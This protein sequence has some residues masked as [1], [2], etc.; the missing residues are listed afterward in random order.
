MMGSSRRVDAAEA[1]ALVRDNRVSVLDVRTPEEYSSLGHIPGAI[2]LPVDLIASAPATLP[3]SGKPL[4]VCCEHGVRSAFA[5]GF[6]ARAG[7]EGVLDLAGGMAGWRGPR[8]HAP[9]GGGE[10]IG[11]ASWLLD[12][13][14]LLPREGTILD[15][16]CGTGRHG[17]LLASAGFQVR[18]IDRDGKRIERL[19]EVAR[20]LG[21]SIDAEVVDLEAP[22]LD[23]GRDRHA[24][25]LVFN[26]LQRSLFAALREALHPGGLLLYETFTEAQAERGHPSNPE[27]LLKPGELQRLAAPLEILRSREG[28]YD[29]RHVAAVAARRGA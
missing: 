5:A 19:R 7:F 12:N 24:A 11:P 1:E 17:L 6:L 3:E 13:A 21:V 28:E 20:R 14:D 18:A 25:I 10:G 29:G 22:G 8:E 15:L 16:A 2:L 4:L 27:F 26:F 23:L 9:A